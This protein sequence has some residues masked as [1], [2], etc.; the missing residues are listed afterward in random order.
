MYVAN[1][2]KGNIGINNNDPYIARVSGNGMRWYSGAVVPCTE[3]GGDA[4]A[5]MDLGSNTVRFKDLYLSGTTFGEKMALGGAPTANDAVLTLLAAEP[6]IMF[7]DTT[8]GSA[9]AGILTNSG[10]ILFKNGANGNNVSDLTERMRINNNGMIGINTSGAN[11]YSMGIHMHGSGNG[12]SLHLTDSSTGSLGGDGVEFLCYQGIG[13]LWNRENNAWIIGTNEQEKVKIHN[14]GLTDWYSSTTAL[15][16]RTGGTGTNT[17]A[18]SAFQGATSTSNGTQS[19]VVYAN[20]NV[21]NSNNSY[22]SISDQNLKENI[23]DATDKL[24]DIKQVKVRNFNFI[25]DSTKQIGV[26]AQE[27]ETIF[28]ALVDTIK[29]SDADGNQLETETKSVKYSVFVPILIKP[30]QEQQTIIEALTARITALEA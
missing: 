11:N 24:S 25:G 30:I 23:V 13:Y 18:L 26:V 9:D 4:N 21:Q 8:G 22:G 3:S 15:R 28:P 10:N 27:L 7:H 2:N 17:Q 5:A 16:V 29:D 20:G 19:F 14:T 1:S 6:A 12:S